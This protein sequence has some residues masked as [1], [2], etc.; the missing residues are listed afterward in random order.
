MENNRKADEPKQDGDTDTEDKLAEAMLAHIG[1]E[2]APPPEE[3]EPEPQED[4]AQPE[5]ELFDLTHEGKQV[6][7]TKAEAR[8]LAMKGYD[9]TQNMQRL[10]EKGR[11]HDKQ[12]ESLASVAQDQ[13]A[14]LQFHSAIEY[15]N[16]Q[17]KAISAL[18]L[19]AVKADSP[20]RY[21]ELVE[22][23]RELREIK[24][25]AADGLERARGELQRNI[26]QAMAKRVEENKAILTR[27]IPGWGD[28]L[29]GELIDYAVS[30]GI[31]KEFAQ[32]VV[33]APMFKILH[34]AYLRDNAI[35]SAAEK[36]QQTQPT[37]IKPGAAPKGRQGVNNDRL[38][39]NLK[40]SGSLQD[41]AKLFERML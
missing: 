31:Q 11:E 39:A 14:F 10:A 30:Q 19:E 4:A 32:Q 40:K 41:A 9:Y 22:K 36:R 18:D 5:E 16:Q 17:I 8:E 23:R 33:E 12:L 2:D 1:D 24:Q 35:K 3:E 27:D 38:K 6:R 7:V 34:K 26:G 15:C 21:Q 20:D 37:G 29:Y 25:D 28:K 13:Q